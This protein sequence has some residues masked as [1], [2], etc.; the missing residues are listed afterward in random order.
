MVC[1]R[2][3][4]TECIDS[5]DGLDSVDETDTL[6]KLLAASQ[7]TAGQTD[8]DS[9]GKKRKQPN[10]EPTPIRPPKKSASAYHF[11]YPTYCISWQERKET[12]DTYDGIEGSSST[13]D[14][15]CGACPAWSRGVF[16]P[17]ECL[18]MLIYY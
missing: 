15:L 6:T 10:E 8:P 17:V 12:R 3:I 9:I 18:H 1:H 2:R 4:L 14:P 5:R 7:R 16:E 11:T 13:S